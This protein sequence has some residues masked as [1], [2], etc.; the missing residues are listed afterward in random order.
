MIQ[1]CLATGPHIPVSCHDLAR[2]VRLLWGR[3]FVLVKGCLDSWRPGDDPLD[4]KN[5]QRKWD[6]PRCPGELDALDAVMV[7]IYTRYKKLH[8]N[9]DVQKP[10]HDQLHAFIASVLP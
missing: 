2:D 6:T 4:Q 3:S 9:E 5:F 1:P 8:P 7:F 10:S